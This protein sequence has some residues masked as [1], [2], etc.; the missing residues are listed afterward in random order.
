MTRCFV[1]AGP[2]LTVLLLGLAE[3]T[4]GQT[5]CVQE[6]AAA[7]RAFEGFT[8]REA[9][10]L[11]TQRIRGAW[12]RA[13][14]CYAAAPALD[15]TAANNYAKTF[16]REAQVLW[17]TG[18]PDEATAV[19]EAFLDG[20]HLRADSAGVRYLLEWRAFI[21]EARSDWEAAVETRLQLL[22]YAPM[23]TP[24]VQARIW[25]MLGSGY[26]KLGWNDE[27]LAIYRKM[28]RELGA[29]DNLSPGLR[30]SLSRAYR[31]EA[32]LLMRGSGDSV[33]GARILKAAHEALRLVTDGQTSRE[34]HYQAF[35][36]T[37]LA[38]AYRA[39][40][41]P[42]SALAAA[43]RSVV[44]ADQLERPSPSAEI[45]GREAVG[46]ALRDLGRSG[47]AVE[48]FE[49]A[50]ALLDRYDVDFQ[51]AI[52]L[53]QL[54]RAYIDLGRLTRADSVITK[55]IHLREADWELQSA[56]A[57][58]RQA[59]TWYR[60]FLTL[61][62]L[63][64]R[65]NRPE[66][67]FLALDEGR[68]R[69]LRDLRRRHRYV[70]APADR[71]RA[72]SLSQEMEELHRRLS[73]R[74]VDLALA[75]RLRGRITEVEKE[76]AG[77][78][79][80]PPTQR[81]TIGQLQRA[82]RD[83]NQILI[84][85]SFEPPAHAFVL[86]ADTFLAV[87]L[88]PT[89]DAD[90]I[91]S[92]QRAIS[93]QLNETNGPVAPVEAS[94]DL[95]PLHTLYELLF[96]PLVTHIPEGTPL[97]VVPEGPLA[98]LPFGLLVTEPV[99]RFRFQDA[100]FLLRRHPITTELA[101]A[102]LLE[103]PHPVPARDLV[104]FGRS[105][106]GG[107]EADSPLRSAYADGAAPD[108]PSVRRELR[109][110]GSRFASATVALDEEATESGLYRRLGDARVLHLASHAFVQDTNPLASYL[111]LTAD[112][113]G[114]EDG[115]LHLYEL[116]EQRLRAAL[117]VLSGCRTARGRDVRGEGTL[118]LQYAVRAAG[119]ESS[120][121]TLW[122]VD[123]AATVE[124]MDGFYK[125]LA[126]GARKDVA[127][128]RAQLEYLDEHEGL[129]ASPFFWGAPVLYG[130]PRPVPLPRSSSLW[131]WI[132]TGLLLAALAVPHLARRRT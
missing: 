106:F 66:E 127:L 130:D 32:E 109:M 59:V 52:L 72:D 99:A 80:E 9:G 36:Y 51:H 78:F 111:Q 4:H 62:S 128:Q 85:Y 24:D 61:T 84:T 50:L 34:H 92:L 25:M 113:D 44:L 115:R 53:D 120:L 22:D 33:E 21:L 54:A 37:T 82:L 117:V 41:R 101:A 43:R 3:P 132:G 28:Q 60:D 67:A 87:P 7:E 119:A 108:L 55:L 103:T 23:S 31:K 126:R 90:R 47:E 16:G 26:S 77:L 18:H 88:E 40:G 2:L 64:L 94:F 57:E 89:L 56:E 27:A 124:L 104:A 39:V 75:V 81:V 125:H 29:L 95:E 5:P 8:P 69:M 129:R 17:E 70:L 98:A 105:R 42:D 110:I 123:D 48:A 114:T 13:R 96:A 10:T 122:R 97:V 49:A 116:I 1:L 93:P 15:S 11:A 86:R 6:Y 112:P 65:Q 102:L 58:A 63:R 83:R 91:Q 46:R 100:P 74:D 131:W 118:G 12:Q 20:P 107:L 71:A 38:G 73:G 14:R 35:A 79:G 19:T 76:R 68:A 30:S 45:T 121:G